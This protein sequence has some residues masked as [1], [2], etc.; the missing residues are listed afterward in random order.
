[1]PRVICAG[2]VNWDVT[3]RVDDL[4]PV[5]GEAT[6]SEQRQSGGGSASNVAVVLAGLGVSTHL[7]GSVGDDEHGR[8][9]REE[10]EAV[11]VDTTLV[12]A[13]DAATSVKYLVVADDGEVMVF[14][15]DGANESFG[16]GDLPDSS[17]AEADHLHLTG[18]DPDTAAAFARLANDVGTPVSFDPGRRLGDRTYEETLAI[19]D[20]VFLNERE[21]RVA[22][23]EDLLGDV[24][25]V[26][27]KRG[28]GGA[29][30]RTG[31]KTV[32]HPGYPV[33]PVDTTG[34]GDAF[35]AGF[36]AGRFE[37]SDER[38]LS[39][40]NACGALAAARTGAR[41]QVDREAVEALLD[42]EQT[43]STD[44]SAASG[45]GSAGSE[46]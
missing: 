45:V 28:A 15:N 20:V 11:G 10:L 27:V 17:L 25:A 26:V 12:E 21:G 30:L 29:E 14:G 41:L 34:A 24:A 46:D 38:A 40:G 18:Q 36:I 5:D 7:L 6:I 37:G 16:P 23:S 39:I 35:A 31:G 13:P 32:T 19:V 4:P 44:P 22:A 9:A 43:D 42:G 33:D 2:H 3:L 1:M 8:S